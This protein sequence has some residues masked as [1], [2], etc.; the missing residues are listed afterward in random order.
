MKSQSH[1]F[2]GHPGSV[3]QV[4]RF[5]ASELEGCDAG[6][7]HDVVLMVSELAANV[8]RHAGTDFEVTISLDRPGGLV[9]IEVQDFSDTVPLP[10]TA[11]PQDTDGRGLEILDRLADAWGFEPRA[12]GAGKKVWFEKKFP[13]S[14]DLSPS[15]PVP[16]VKAV[17]DGLHDAIVATDGAGVI[18]YINPAAE[19]L[20]GW[21]SETLLGQPAAILVPESM[22]GYLA[23]GFTAFVSGPAAHMTGRQLR[24]VIRRHDGTDLHTQLVLSIFEH[25]LAGLV[26]VGVFRPAVDQRLENWS[27]LTSELLELVAGASVDDPPAERLL[28]IIGKRLRWDVTTLWTRTPAGTLVCRHVWSRTPAVAPAFMEEK[29]KDPTNGSRGLPYWV[30]EHSEPIWV[31]DL[32]EDGR[33]VTDAVRRDG[34]QSAYAF[35]VRYRGQ[36]VGVIKMLSR[37]ERQPDPGIVDLMNAIGDHLGELLYALAQA[38][39]RE[40]LVAELQAVRRSQEFLLAATHVLSEVTDYREMVQRLAQVAV[41]VLADLCLIDIHNEHGDIER[42]AAWHADPAKRVLT[43][44]LRRAYPPQPMGSHPSID[45]MRTGQSRWGAEMSDEFLLATSQDDRHFEILKLLEFTSY[46]T[47]PLQV[48]DRVLGTV[49]L[50]SAGSQRHFTEDDLVVAEQLATQVASVVD[51]ARAYDFER[52]ISH[53]LQRNLLPD[54]LPWLEG[55]SLTARYVPGADGVEVGGDWYDVVE[56]DHQYVALIVGDVEGHDMEAAKV[57]SRLRHILNLLVWEDRAPGAAL[58]RVNR[59]LVESDMNRIT[60]ALVA[61]LD[62]K[63]GQLTIASAGHPSPIALGP[64]GSR[65]LTVEP[66]PPLGVPGGAYE[67]ASFTLADDCLI[68]FTDGLYERRDI[69]LD[70]ARASLHDIAGSSR[71]FDPSD[72]AD[73]LLGEGRG[74]GA[75]LDDVAVLALRRR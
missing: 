63:S 60:T 20:F 39:E 67:E 58:A 16:G 35:P 53:T 61:V 72:V 65:D 4:R 27:Q 38:A 8:T 33:F 29:T 41:P 62:T 45:V 47:V 71:T 54:A 23:D 6:I 22:A 68:M 75:W 26:V 36:A 52:Q 14:P 40:Q 1:T 69:R 34:L 5:A 46:M 59:F 44:E 10:R 57:M 51:R 56:L 31:P 17:M 55:W 19:Q 25:P 15:W 42:M 70:V 66:G 64:D 3:A 13:A 21:P 18:R 30:F 37:A 28:S 2:P 43:E 73:C 49:T 48:R 32:L 24:A 50:V 11:A 9:R 74:A 12:D 7:R